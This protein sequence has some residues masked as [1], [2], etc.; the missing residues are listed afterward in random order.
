L[1]SQTNTNLPQVDDLETALRK[2]SRDINLSRILRERGIARVYLVSRMA[3]EAGGFLF[4]T[5][6]NPDT[7]RPFKNKSELISWFTSHAKVPRSLYYIREQTYDRLLGI[8]KNMEES[9][10][11]VLQKPHIIWKVLDSLGTWDGGNLTSIEPE[12]AARMVGT[13]LGK[14]EEETL[15]QLTLGDE[16]ENQGEILALSSQAID[17][18]ID[19]V[20]VHESGR[21]AINYVEND[22]IGKPE[23]SY[24]WDEEK[25]ALVIEI[26]RRTIDETGNVFISSI[27]KVL[28]ARIDSNERIPRDIR[29]DLIDRLPVRGKYLL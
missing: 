7:G 6:I 26:V 15:R 27:E 1:L 13:Y 18:L 12:V 2:A 9:F 3:S 11:T 29:E 25:E 19:E 21:D 20:A 28:L 16:F 17:K 24:V 23:I 22:I 8:G 4:Q 14:E 10:K 5:R